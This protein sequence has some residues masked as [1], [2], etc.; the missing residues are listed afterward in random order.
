MNRLP[1]ASDSLLEIKTPCPKRWSELIGDDQR[2]FCS[3]CSLHVHNAAQLTREETTE[4][5]TSSESRVC[6]RIEYDAHGAPLFREPAP[7]A[8]S[9]GVARNHATRAARWALSAVAGLLAAC[10]G[11]VQPST[12]PSD[13]QPNGGPTSTRMGEVCTTEKLGDVAAPREPRFEMMGGVSP[14]PDPTELSPAE[15]LERPAGK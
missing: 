1:P 13:G 4:L 15:P 3:A 8:A 12:P 10:N 7:A 9:A 6:L 11:S 5:V 2:R 14:E